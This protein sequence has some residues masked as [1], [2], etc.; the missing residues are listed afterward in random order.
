M[1]KGAR[2]PDGG[3]VWLSLNLE[4]IRSEPGG[5]VRAVAVTFTD[6]T[7][8]RE[9]VLRLKDNE[10]RLRHAL[11]GSADGVLDWAAQ[12]DRLSLGG[13]V[14]AFLGE[15]DGSLPP[16]RAGWLQRV[17]PEEEP[18]VTEQLRQLRLGAV[19]RLDLEYRVRRRDGSHGWIRERSKV[20]ELTA[21]GQ[22][23]RISGTLTDIDSTKQAQLQLEAAFKEKERLVEEL[24]EALQQVK[25]L[26][27]LLPICM[28]C[29][30]IRNDQGYWDR[31][32]KYFTDRTGVLFSHG[33]C[34]SCHERYYPPPA[35]E[36]QGGCADGDGSGTPL[37][38]PPRD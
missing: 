25:T 14:A 24:Q 3:S 4:P 19:E 2:G 10:L 33:L 1:A 12:G 7:S 18:V 20:V 9:L 32:E 17:H 16:T 15:P 34:P 29:H 28:H 8:H 26:T 23:R 31:L 30:K 37:P 38:D 5:P 22:A 13:A 35:G 11:D 36:C 6:I 27:G 21:T